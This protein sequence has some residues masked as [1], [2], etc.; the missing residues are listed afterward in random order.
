MGMQRKYWTLLKVIKIKRVLLL[1]IYFRSN[2][3]YADYTVPKSD[4][5]VSSIGQAKKNELDPK[6]VK[7]LIWNL[8]KGQRESFE[9]S[10][11][12]LVKSKDILILQE[13]FL[14]KKMTSLF[15]SLSDF[16]FIG[17][18]SFMD[19]GIRTGVLTAS[20]SRVI[21]SK[22][23]VSNFAE[24]FTQTPKMSLLSYFAV[25]GFKSQLLVVNTHAINF[26]SLSEYENQINEL[27]LKINSY[28][29]PVIFAG[30][31]NTWS[32]GRIEI[33]QNYT[34]KLKLKEVSFDKDDRLKFFGRPLDHIYYSSGIQLLKA[35][36]RG[37]L[38]GSDH[39]PIEVEFLLEQP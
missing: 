31:F 29:G 36:V 28:G 5:V 1:I 10:F 16:S 19:S 22:Y 18:T 9:T 12:K 37:E 26:V 14:D 4:N 6:S 23:I 35:S 15:T 8:Y 32:A 30:D 21:D 13:M 11:V 20:Q 27:Y 38:D 3:I 34:K 25:R 24:P 17:A 2:L 7:L 33:L 39:K